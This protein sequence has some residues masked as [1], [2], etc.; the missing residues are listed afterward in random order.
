MSVNMVMR[1]VNL[2]NFLAWVFVMEVFVRR[3]RE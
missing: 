1:V 2:A 3:S